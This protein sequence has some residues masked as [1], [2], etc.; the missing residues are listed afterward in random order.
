MAW[1]HL[2]CG[3]FPSRVSLFSNALPR[4]EKI[5]VP[6]RRHAKSREA[7]KEHLRR[8]FQRT[9]KIPFQQAQSQAPGLNLHLHL[10]LHQTAGVSSDGS[11]PRQTAL[12]V[13]W[14]HVRLKKQHSTPRHLAQTLCMAATGGVFSNIPRG[15]NIPRYLISA[16]EELSLSSFT[17]ATSS[18]TSTAGAASMLI[19]HMLM[20]QNG[21]RTGCVGC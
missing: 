11:D 5:H 2:F 18:S 17:L 13:L 14:Q 3:V 12:R 21:T 8:S 9:F 16:D 15:I 20:F 10:G 4:L 7:T 6:S 19:F 1:H